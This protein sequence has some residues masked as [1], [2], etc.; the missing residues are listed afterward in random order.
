MAGGK[1]TNPPIYECKGCDMDGVPINS[2]TEIWAACVVTPT[3]TG[4]TNSGASLQENSPPPE[5]DPGNLV[6]PVAD[7]AWYKKSSSYWETQ[8]AT[9][10]GMLGGLDNLHVR[11]INASR[12]FLGILESRHGLRV[13]DGIALDVGAGIGRI[14]KELLLPLFP[15]VDMLDQNALYLEESVQYLKPCSGDFRNVGVVERR[16]ACGMQ[17]FATEDIAK[18]ISYNKRY[19]LIFVQWCII[20]LDDN[21]FV[22]HVKTQLQ[23]LAEGGILVIKDNIMNAGKNG[24]CLDRSDNSIMRS[25]KYMKSLFARSRARVIA[26]QAQTDMPRNTFPVRMYA[27]VSDQAPISALA[28]ATRRQTRNSSNAVERT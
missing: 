17:D 26:E 15:V 23:N 13:K 20:Y 28:A 4:A 1:D 22:R 21:D 9:V 10:C 5:S 12:A 24:F 2:N 14:T 3:S 8:D 27:L 19:S 11:D 7:G 16:I 18:G 6:A 25:D